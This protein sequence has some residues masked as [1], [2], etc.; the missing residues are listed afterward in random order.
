[1][2]YFKEIIS[3][4]ISAIII[5]PEDS[6]TDKAK[7]IIW[8]VFIAAPILLIIVASIIF[9][10]FT[11]STDIVTVP[12]LGGSNIYKALE[13]LS[14][15]KLVANVSAKYSETIEEG[16]VFSQNPIQGSPVK[17]GSSVS[18]SVSL[19]TQKVNIPDLKGIALI[20]LDLFLSKEYPNSKIPFKIAP[21]V[22]ETNDSIEKGII[23]KQD[24]A[25]GT[26][27][28][29]AKLVKIWVSNGRKD[30]E[31]ETLKNYKGKKFDEIT[32]ELSGLE[33]L[34]TFKYELINDKDKD[35]IIINQSIN[36]GTQISDIINQNKILI[37][38]VN[39]YQYI[40]NEKISGIKNIEI[41]RKAL[42]YLLEIK[43]K[44]DME[45]NTVL[46]LYTKGG[47]SVPIPYQA[48]SNGK[49]IINI[50]GNFYKED[51]LSESINN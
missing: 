24:P 2:E 1:M 27:I 41:P 22:Y 20:D 51:I 40:N 37:L 17:K 50:D 30:G 33:L 36:E 7:K 28:K 11:F 43:I 9:V 3:N 15:K 14:E 12:N 16:I 31:I 18:L 26:S 5:K 46:K 29:K 49:L 23:F 42:K 47:V 32:G 39:K 19:G 25:E 8:Y 6:E 13:K 48:K 34:F 38:T 35:G 45:E 44:N 10:T 4:I 21:P